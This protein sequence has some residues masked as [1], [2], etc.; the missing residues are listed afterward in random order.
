MLENFI[1][2]ISIAMPIF[3]VMCIG[4]FLKR[5]EVINEEFIKTAN[6][7][8]FN[9]AL[10]IK[11]F[12]DV[13]K[14]SFGEYFDA[15]F[16][17][18]TMVGTITSVLIIWIIASLFIK[19]KTQ[20]GAF[21]HGSFRGNFL[22]IGLTLMEN[23]TGSIGIKAPLIIA[24]IIPLYNILAIIILTYTD[25]SRSSKISFKD[26]ILSIGKNPLI[27]AI[28]LGIIFSLTGLEL[29]MIA[30]RTMS[31]FGSLVTPLALITI[32]ASF[33]FMN[34]SRNLKPAIIASIIKLF[35]MPVIVVFFTMAMNFSNEDVLLIYLLFGVPSA[36]VSYIMTAAMNGDKDLAANIIMIT[37]I[38]S[39]I[40]MTIFIF[41]FKT[42]GII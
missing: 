28:L 21:I 16:I 10:P 6:F 26:T 9:V 3:F 23:I 40:S 18:F 5:K 12:N 37:T 31:Y 20:V 35:F 15:K 39:T 17:A 14:T 2:S 42:I 27:K 4:Y 11:L 36:T 19:D 41:V 38:L 32:G 33:N 1:F 29:P 22:Y 13:S 8:I 34:I 30:T 7:I 25:Q 24:I